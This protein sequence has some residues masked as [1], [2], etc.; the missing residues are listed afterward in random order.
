MLREDYVQIR[1]ACQ[2]T[3]LLTYGCGRAYKL[4]LHNAQA[5]QLF[6]QNGPFRLSHK[7]LVTKSLSSL[8]DVLNKLQEPVKAA[9]RLP[10]VELLKRRSTLED[11]ILRSE[12]K[13]QLLLACERVNK[14]SGIDDYV[15]KATEAI[16]EGYN[17]NRY[18]KELII[19]KEQ[20]VTDEAEAQTAS[21][22]TATHQRSAEATISNAQS[23]INQLSMVKTTHNGRLL[24]KRSRHTFTRQ[25][26]HL[27]RKLRY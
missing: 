17:V 20:K 8:N 19:E 1:N 16:E 14:E 11:A 22:P 9:T 18:L 10:V 24:H 23:S 15:N 4:V 5:Y 25:S 2:L 12:S 7:K 13:L 6:V 26:S 3:L 21:N 27:S